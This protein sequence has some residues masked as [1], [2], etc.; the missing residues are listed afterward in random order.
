MKLWV[1]DER[2]APD[3]TWTVAKTYDEACEILD[4]RPDLEEV[5]L[6]YVLKGWDSGFDVL[7]YMEK[8]NVWPAILRTHSSSVTGRYQIFE[9]ARQVAPATTHVVA[10]F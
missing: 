1:D 6:D 10:P 4:T 8:N 3:D 2:P 9:H 7:R 5:S